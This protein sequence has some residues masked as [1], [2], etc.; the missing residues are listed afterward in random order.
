MTHAPRPPGGGHRENRQRVVREWVPSITAGEAAPGTLG[1]GYLQ[2]RPQ[3]VKGRPLGRDMADI[4][5]LDAMGVL[6][7]AGDDVA[8]LLVPFVGKHGHAGLSA[9]AIDR[10]YVEASLGRM[11]TEAFWRRMGV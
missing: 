6:Y 9:E 4:L 3:P 11:D 10:A 7:E 1:S 2:G 5:I 8:E